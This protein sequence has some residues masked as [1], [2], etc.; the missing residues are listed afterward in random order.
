MYDTPEQAYT[1]ATTHLDYAALNYDAQ[2]IVATQ[3]RHDLGWALIGCGFVLF[4]ILLLAR[5]PQPQA[6][7]IQ[8]PNY[9]YQ[10][11]RVC[12]GIAVCN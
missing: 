7:A 11:N 10:D 3:R 12:I 9:S 2:P 5:L 1:Q 4:L 8:Q 6:P